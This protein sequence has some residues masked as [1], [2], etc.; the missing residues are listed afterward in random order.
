MENYFWYVKNPKRN[1]RVLLARCY[2]ED[3]RIVYPYIYNRKQLF[4][5]WVLLVVKKSIELLAIHP[6]PPHV[7]ST[8]RFCALLAVSLVF[9]A[10]ISAAVL[11]KPMGN[12]QQYAMNI[13]GL[14]RG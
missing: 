5:S 7:G 11:I 14:R 6:S 3:P 13:E 1:T 12:G 8:I 9:G 10:R 4:M 2:P